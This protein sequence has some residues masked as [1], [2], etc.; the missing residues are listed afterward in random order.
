MMAH[1]A[2]IEH[3]VMQTH[4]ANHRHMAGECYS[5]GD[6]VYLLTKNLAL[7]K[8]RAKKLLP[9]FIG[10]YNVVEAHA[11]ALTVMLELPPKLIAQWVYPTFHMSLIWAHIP[12]NHRQWKIST[13]RHEI[14]LRFQSNQ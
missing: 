10:P 11:T 12:N 3:R 6:L 1:D 4:H 5:L 8:G 2:I 13:S 7:P 14:V 9:K